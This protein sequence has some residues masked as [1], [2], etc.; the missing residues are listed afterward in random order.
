MSEKQIEQCP[1]TG[2][3]SRF[4]CRK[5]P[6]D[7]YYTPGIGLIYQKV[8]PTVAQM[9]D[10]ADKEYSAG[11]YRDYVSAAPLKK[12]TF[13]RRIRIL[14]RLGAKGR[15]LDVGC[16]CGFFIEVALEHGFD[17]Y[18]V[19]F[20]AQ[21]VSMAAPEIQ[22]RIT[23]GD[24][25][26]LRNRLTEQFDVVV[27]FDIIEHTQNPLQFLADIRQ[28][29]RPGGWLLLATPDTGHFLR[30]VMGRNWP[31]LQPMQHTFLFSKLA[32]RLVLE[33]SGY[34]NIGVRNAD[35]S[36]TLNYLME[37]VRVHNPTIKRAY[38]KL[39][40]VLPR[41]VREGNF[42]VNIGEMLAYAQRDP[43]PT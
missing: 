35:K 30:Y 14:E 5:P 18:G 3:E 29:L 31:M 4:Y 36:L 9:E 13:E 19:E 23:I 32:M 26:L 15:L 42:A 37:Q 34:E 7:Y 38:D 12:A 1:I 10:Y 33:K 21:A 28:V 24:V 17:A 2:A 11:V 27:A 16:A 6:T 43:E 41:R 40:R 22:P 39:S 25:N 20:S 8:A